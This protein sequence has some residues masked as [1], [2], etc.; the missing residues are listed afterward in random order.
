M[1]DA[2]ASAAER[3]SFVAELSADVA[4]QLH[5]FQEA[6][7]ALAR[8]DSA[9]RAAFVANLASNVAALIGEVAEDRRG[10][11]DAFFATTSVKEKPEIAK[12]ARA[13]APSKSVQVKTE[14]PPPVQNFASTEP[15]PANLEVALA[16]GV[17][18]SGQPDHAEAPRDEH[19]T[20]KKN[21]HQEIKTEADF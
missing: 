17:A 12:P 11:R 10:A 1:S 18:D 5:T 8:S 20:N 21:R 15:A 7:A 2:A 13:N 6:F 16:S 14:T 9:E 3:K 4:N 19:K